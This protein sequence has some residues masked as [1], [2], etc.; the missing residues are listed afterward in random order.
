L[1]VSVQNKV[2][3]FDLIL[4]TRLAGDNREINEKKIHVKDAA[5]TL[6]QKMPCQKP[7]RLLLPLSLSSLSL[8]LS[9]H[10]RMDV[11]LDRALYRSKMD[12]R[13]TLTEMTELALL[14]C[15]FKRSS[16]GTLLSALSQNVA[17]AIMTSSNLSF[18]FPVRPREYQCDG[19]IF[20]FVTHMSCTL[21]SIEAPFCTGN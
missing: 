20:V 4:P 18:P 13:T 11:T 5:P 1:F 15:C 6:L 2:Y 10:S 12:A 14:F 16:C 8:S 17:V 9:L 3:A 19:V 21:Q 7:L